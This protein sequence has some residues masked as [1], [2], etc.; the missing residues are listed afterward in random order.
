MTTTWAALVTFVPTLI[1]V[2]FV[3]AIDGDGVSVS[4]VLRLGLGGWLL[5][6]GVP[7]RLEHGTIGLVPLAVSVFI[8]WR[9]GRAGVHTARAVGARRFRSVLPTLTAGVGVGVAYSL[10]GAGAAAVARTPGMHISVPRAA[11]TLAGYGLVAGSIGAATESRK[12]LRAVATLPKLVVDGVRTGVVA[13]LLILGA[14]GAMAGMSIALDGGRASQYLSVYETGVVGQ[15]GLTFVCLVY[16]PNAAIWA[17]SY[18]VGP[19]FQFGSGSRI[20]VVDVTRGP[21]PTVPALAGMPEQSVPAWASV[22]L[23]GLPLVAALAAGWL[24]ARR[25]GPPAARS[26]ASGNTRF[27]WRPW[28]VLVATGALA[29]VVSG[30]LLGLV[31]IASSGSLG[32]ERMADIGPRIMPVT[33]IGAGVVGIG[34][35]VASVAYRLLIRPAERVARF[36]RR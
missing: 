33:L 24:L 19:G 26:T 25:T 4:G 16:S 23:L 12:L 9:V 10:I 31:S 6:H 30:A 15:A 8:A 2:G 35:I 17:A 22:L 11:L 27:D 13:A 28:A 3:Y 34:V 21:E 36:R 1:I 5:A 29:G 32:S 14:G 20:S 7:L 18:L